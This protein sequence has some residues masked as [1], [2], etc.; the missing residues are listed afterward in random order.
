VKTADWANSNQK[1][2]TSAET[3]GFILRPWS[4]GNAANGP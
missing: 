4:A 2:L 3:S 1:F